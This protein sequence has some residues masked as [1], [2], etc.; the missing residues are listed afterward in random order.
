MYWIDTHLHFGEHMED[1]S[2]FMEECRLAS[3]KKVLLCAG[4]E[5]NALKAQKLSSE[6]EEICYAVGVHPHEAV[7]QK[8]FVSSLTNYFSDPKLAACG[9]IGLDYYY[10]FSPREEQ[11]SCFEAQLDLALQASLPAVV[12]CRDKENTFLAYEDAYVLLK[13]FA[14]KGGRYV[15]HC[16]AGSPEFAAKFLE[17]G[18]YFGVG[19]MITFNKADNIRTLAQYLPLERLLAETDA[20]Y[21]APKPHRG[22]VNR[23]GYIPIIGEM[24]AQ[25]KG[26]TPEECQRATT[27]N[28]I[29]LFGDRMKVSSPEE[30]QK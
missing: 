26:I 8:S 20:P 29:R 7:D 1:V 4:D 2:A 3:V 14:E 27:E 13:P 15:L 12:H 24:L 19:G 22:K 16:Y 6:Y 18:A 30:D 11:I 28:A 9:E 25:V 17:T 10:D 5:E 23:S 21:L